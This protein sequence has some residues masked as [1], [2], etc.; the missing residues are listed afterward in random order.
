MA[1]VKSKLT[2][3]ATNQGRTIKRA[4]RGIANVIL[5]RAQMLAPVDSGKL[6]KD[7]RVVKNGDHVAVRFGSANVPYARR[8]HFENKRNPQTLHFLTRAGDSAAKENI[9]KY[10]EVSR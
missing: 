7:G 5:S 4:E 3:W 6:V 1:V 9:R 8:R 2:Q 10:I